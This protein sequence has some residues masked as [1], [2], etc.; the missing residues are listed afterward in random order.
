ME[1][2]LRENMKSPSHIFL[3]EVLKSDPMSGVRY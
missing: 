2:F 1:T 3:K